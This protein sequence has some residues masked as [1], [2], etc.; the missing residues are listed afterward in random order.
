MSS[1][2]NVEL[3]PSAELQ[4]NNCTD[5]DQ[6]K[7]QLEQF[8]QE[9]AKMKVGNDEPYPLTVWVDEI[10]GR[11]FVLKYEDTAFANYENS[12][13]TFLD[14][15]CD[16]FVGAFSGFPFP[17]TETSSRF[18]ITASDPDP[19]QESTATIA[20]L[21]ATSEPPDVQSNLKSGL[22]F[23]EIVSCSATEEIPR[24]TTKQIDTP[25]GSITVTTNCRSAQVSCSVQDTSLCEDCDGDEISCDDENDELCRKYTYRVMVQ[26]GCDDNEVIE[27][28][29]FFVLG[30]ALCLPAINPCIEVGTKTP[31]ETTQAIIDE[32]V[33]KLK[34]E[35]KDSCGRLV[36][37][38]KVQV[39]WNQSPLC[40]R[41]CRAEVLNEITY[42]VIATPSAL[43]FLGNLRE[44]T[45]I[46]SEPLV[47]E[48]RVFDPSW[49]KYFPS[50]CPCEC[51]RAQSNETPI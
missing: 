15:A 29:D 46:T 28:V 10:E 7:T 23:C 11:N 50:L 51:Q 47:Q 6:L 21:I 33:L 48:V 45:E 43:D 2:I 34:N 17:C 1:T 40:S 19:P 41:C 27:T 30:K 36:D 20:V 22:V 25:F 18:S 31:I 39:F 13:F 4:V 16:V 44:C 5:C 14:N 9:N 32:N 37:A 38:A 26:D 42:T 3:S 49:E 8:V 24:D 12:T 35:T